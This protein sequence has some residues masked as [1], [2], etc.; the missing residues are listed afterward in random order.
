MFCYSKQAQ[1]EHRGWELKDG[2]VAE[3]EGEGVRGG[4][5]SVGWDNI[6]LQGGCLFKPPSPSVIN[7]SRSETGTSRIVTRT[8]FELRVPSDSVLPVT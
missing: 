2:R 6:S 5:G 7:T 4:G 8:L 3:P 1:Q